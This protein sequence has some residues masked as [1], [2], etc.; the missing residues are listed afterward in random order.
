MSLSPARS[1]RMPRQRLKLFS[2]F[3]RYVSFI[4][5]FCRSFLSTGLSCSTNGNNISS[6][7]QSKRM[8]K[9]IL[10]SY[11]SLSAPGPYQHFNPPNP[12]QAPGM[13]WLSTSHLQHNQP[14][15]R[16]LTRSADFPELYIGPPRRA[17]G[18]PEGSSK[19]KRKSQA[20]TSS[21]PGNTDLCGKSPR[22][23]TGS[24]TQVRARRR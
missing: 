20:S 4:S 5:R 17:P 6:P 19:S 2:H 1:S 23:L 14:E 16:T 24:M 7:Q 21:L 11:P 8:P 22:S 12:P 18:R 10:H 13:S 9:P 15:P 3:E